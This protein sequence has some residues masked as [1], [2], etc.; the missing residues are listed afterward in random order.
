MHIYSERMLLVFYGHNS[1]L[2]EW[3]R[4]PHQAPDISA[5]ELDVQTVEFVQHFEEMLHGRGDPITGPDQD[6]IE[7]T[8]AGLPASRHRI[9]AA[10]LRPTDPVFILMDDPVATLLGH[11]AQVIEL[12]FRVLI[13]RGQT[14]VQGRTLHKGCSQVFRYV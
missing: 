13:E 3:M 5:D 2:D 10:G 8:A 1:A 14:H 7:M 4:K 12:G 6:H 11:L 9:Q